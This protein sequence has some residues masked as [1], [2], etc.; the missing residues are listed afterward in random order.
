M[1]KR[2]SRASRARARTPCTKVLEFWRDS[3]Y[4]HTDRQYRDPSPTGT[5]NSPQN[6]N[7]VE[8][9]VTSRNTNDPNPYIKRFRKIL[10]LS[11]SSLRPS[12]ERRDRSHTSRPFLLSHN[13]SHC[14]NSYSSSLIVADPRLSFCSPL[15]ILLTCSSTVSILSLSLSLSICFKIDIYTW[16]WWLN[17]T[18][19]N[20]T[21]EFLKI[22]KTTSL[23]LSIYDDDDWISLTT[24][25]FRTLK[26][27]VS[28]PLSIDRSLL[29]FYV[30]Y[31]FSLSL[32]IYFKIWYLWWWLNITHNN[33]K[34]Q[35]NLYS[36]SLSLWERCFPLS[37]RRFWKVWKFIYDF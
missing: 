8:S 13:V 1:K 24:I 18:H 11:H 26:Y 3:S 28:L 20:N 2:Y 14:S 9:S 25:Y 33:I 19:N 17:I 37:T 31:V 35:K 10:H 5:P 4:D 27:W 6:T 7:H 21:I 16:W 12:S 23:Y 34:F 32:S 30:F 29:R 15:L 22:S 36:L